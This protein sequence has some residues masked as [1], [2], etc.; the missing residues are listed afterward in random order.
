M[1]RGG[2]RPGAGIK[3]GFKYP[4]TLEKEAARQ[5]QRDLVLAHLDPLTKA[6]IANAL[7]LRH[8]FMRDSKTGQ[9]VRLTEPKQI[10]AALNAGDEGSYYWT[11]TKDPSIAAFTDL[12]NRALDKPK[13]QEQELKHS[14]TLVIRHELGSG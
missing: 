5:F 14:G 10:E 4:K 9:F 2:K 7:G 3:K 6:Q 12:M 11:F 1:A 13:E 8:T